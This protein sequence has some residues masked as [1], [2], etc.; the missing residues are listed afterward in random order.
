LDTRIPLRKLEVFVL[1]VDLQSMSRV[2]ERLF[3]TQPVITSHVRFLEDRLGVDLLYRDGRR[4]LPTEGGRI[5]YRWAQDMLARS[6]E[7]AREISGVAE[8]TRGSVVVASSMTTGSYVLPG[9]LAR[10]QQQHPD[11][12]ITL[13]VSDPEHAVAAVAAGTADL[14]VVIEDAE[15]IRGEQLEHEE[16][17]EEDLVLVAAPLSEPRA[18]SIPIGLLATLPFICSPPGLMRRELVDRRLREHHVTGRN[19]VMSVGH[20]EAMKRATSECLGVTLM[21]RSAVRDELAGGRLREIAINDA[22]LRVPILLVQRRTKS[23]SPVQLA[24][25]EVIRGHFAE[26]RAPLEELSVGSGSA[27]G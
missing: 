20:P 24:L 13:D 1:V 6:H 7:M 10:F 18:A 8:G 2:A 11:A 12:E 25:R 4:M 14:A 22:R 5:V 9:L 21:Y 15:Q 27:R 26:S 16:L 23:F 3:L 17:A 19:I